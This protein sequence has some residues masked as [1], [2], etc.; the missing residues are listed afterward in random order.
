MKS[1]QEVVDEVTEP[2]VEAVTQKTVTILRGISGAGKST[3]TAKHFSDAVVCS[4]D[5]YF[6]RD[7][8]YKFDPTKL[9][10]AHNWCFEVFEAACASGR[11]SIVLDNTN[12]MLKEFKRY[13]DVAKTRGYKVNVIRLVVDPKVA[14]KRNVHGVPA[15]KVQQMQDRF[16]DYPGETLV[17]TS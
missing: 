7:G 10:K 11:L 17:H 16:V 9:G 1:F 5:H 6:G 4:A 2:L 3:Y 8:S 14:A 12:T 15:E 13:I